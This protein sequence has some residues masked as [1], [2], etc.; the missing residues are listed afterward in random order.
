[1]A[2]SAQGIARDLALGLLEQQWQP[3]HL[4]PSRADHPEA[5]L[6][7]CLHESIALRE[8]GRPQL[9]LE[10]LTAVQQAGL[11]NPWLLDNQARALVALGERQ[12]AAA[13]WQRLT[14]HSDAAVAKTARDMAALQEDSLRNALGS[15]CARV[16]WVPRHLNTN[17]GSPLIERV[18]QEIITARELNAAQL[19]HD[20]AATT[21][22][23]GWRDPWLHDN[24]AR[25]L[26][27]LQREPEALA[28]WQELQ[29]H[30]GLKHAKAA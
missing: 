9:S 19:S 23:Q 13:L 5:L 7:L 29:N 20:L 8:N 21:L 24:Q 11:Q 14:Q 18:L 4:S 1:M 17:D 3:Q 6:E 30:W 28:I 10:L 15:V 27:H 26:V 22:E 2:N 12:A 25:A 16:G